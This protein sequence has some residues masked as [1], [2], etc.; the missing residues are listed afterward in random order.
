MYHNLD[1][2]VPAD[3][4]RDI[5]SWDNPQGLII[6]S[7]FELVENLIHHNCVDH[8]FDIRECTT[9]SCTDNMSG[10]WFQHKGSATRI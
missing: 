8:C 2:T 6:S 3:S 4:V 10:M 5:V 9:L 7:D 1:I